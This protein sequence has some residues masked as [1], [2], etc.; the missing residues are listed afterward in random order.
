MTLLVGAGLLY[1]SFSNLLAVE[2]GFD[3]RDVTVA[4]LWLPAPNDPTSS[5]YPNQPSRTR[6]MRRLLERLRAVPGV[7]AVAMGTG[8]SI[9]LAGA[10]VA[11][12]RI[13]G[14]EIPDNEMPSAQVA[15]V[16]PDYFKTLGVRLVGG[17]TFRED[18]D[19]QNRVVVIDETM[20]KRYWKRESPIGRH[21]AF[22]L[23][24]Q[25]RWMEIVGVIA[26]IKTDR[27]DSPDAPHIFTCL[28]Q[29]SG[30]A[31]AVFL[32]MARGKAVLPDVLRREVEAVDRDLPLYGA[33]PMDDV[34]ARALARW[35][36]ALTLMGAF[37][38]VA[39]VLAALGIYGV[40][41]FSVGQRTREIGLRI[42]IGA[43]GR[44]I[45]AMILGEGLGLIAI[46]VTAGVAGAV[47]LARFLRTL[48][49]G[50]APNDP[51]TY[52]AM[53]L[54]LAVVTILACYLPAARA[55]RIDPAVP[56][57]SE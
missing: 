23:G 31:M 18:D 9:P 34:I 53:A 12:F 39:L 30:N 28:Y 6:M 56:L 48:L 29:G 5:P 10:Q 8:T 7:H 55:M 24:G 46:G 26:R 54:A 33:R 44:H 38:V 32:K 15:G 51:T 40:T 19:G 49:F 57:R 11:N 50:V 45:L 41:A 2:A 47:A 25:P 22:G 52:A 17:R 37:A 21:I 14:G 1:R 20:A 36:F 43:G 42:A 4:Q 16:T 13:E 35:R 27:L 3:S